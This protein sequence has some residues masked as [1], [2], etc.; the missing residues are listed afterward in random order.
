VPDAGTV[1]RGTLVLERRI[2][3]AALLVALGLLVLLVTLLRIHP[4]AFVAFAVVG[5]PLVAAGILVFL[6]SLITQDTRTEA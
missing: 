3:I 6:Y 2:R 1:S 4:L 5:L